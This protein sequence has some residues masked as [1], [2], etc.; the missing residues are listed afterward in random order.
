MSAAS[1]S[2]RRLSSSAG[3]CEGV[4][5]AVWS[6]PG[7]VGTEARAFSATRLTMSWLLDL[8]RGIQAGRLVV[9]AG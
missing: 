8:K 3:F 7:H 4:I 1:V 2:V 5:A 9:N 6:R